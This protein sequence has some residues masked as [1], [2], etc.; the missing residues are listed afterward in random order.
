MRRSLYRP[1]R[2]TA[3]PLLYSA[4]AVYSAW[5]LFPV[6]WVLLT[7][8]KR[9]ADALSVPP[10]LLFRPTPANYANVFVTVYQFGEVIANS[11]VVAA[12]GTAAII[13]L[14]LPA[15]YGLSRLLRFGRGFMGF[16]IISAR[17]FPT[18]G[19]G[20]PLFILMQN[21]NLLNT[22]FAVIVANV[23]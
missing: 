14:A 13:V 15:A 23:A 20:I 10:Q 21:A 12:L 22:R 18:I 19:L 16:G 3:R 6:I 9:N 1:L 4:L 5:A 2:R 11:V 7:S 17:T 8:F